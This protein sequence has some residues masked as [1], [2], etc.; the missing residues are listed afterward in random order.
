MASDK[1]FL[2]SG[3]LAKLHNHDVTERE[4][5]THPRHCC[6]ASVPRKRTL[7]ATGSIG[8]SRP[9]LLRSKVSIE[10]ITLVSPCLPKIGR[11]EHINVLAT[12]GVGFSR[13]GVNGLAGA[14]EGSQIS[15]FGCG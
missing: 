8:L 4:K 11:R 10:W 6:G 14:V 12:V 13:Y 9:S 3:V 5:M 7:M 15:R 1:P 2:T